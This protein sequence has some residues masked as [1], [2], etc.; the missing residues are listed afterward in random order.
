M[1]RNMND[2]SNDKNVDT[3]VVFGIAPPLNP[4]DPRSPMTMVI[5]IP[6]PAYERIKNGD[7][8]T[9]NLEK[10]G[11]PVHIVIFGAE[12]HQDAMGLL[13]QH[14][15]FVNKQF[16]DARGADFDIK[17]EVDSEAKA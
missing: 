11:L 14:N 5:G 7:T 9:I 4:Q 8:H 2:N 15:S 10:V 16:V 6:G 1:E 17:T 3:N 12:S 13:Q